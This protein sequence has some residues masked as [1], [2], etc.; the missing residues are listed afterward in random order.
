MIEL[1]PS[2]APNTETGPAEHQLHIEA[3]IFGL[4]DRHRLYGDN[5]SPYR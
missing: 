4:S 2:G 1:L 3:E 5:C